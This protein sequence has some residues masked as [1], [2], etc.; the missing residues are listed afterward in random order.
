MFFSFSLCTGMCMYFAIAAIKFC[1]D[2]EICLSIYY[3][4]GF[5]SEFFYTGCVLYKGYKLVG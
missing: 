5:R 1:G 4:V 2:F 3:D